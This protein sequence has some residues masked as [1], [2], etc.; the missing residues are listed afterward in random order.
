MNLV[1]SIN[2]TLYIH[3][4]EV[5]L[6][7]LLLVALLVTFVIVRMKKKNKEENPGVTKHVYDF[8]VEKLIIAEPTNPKTKARWDYTRRSLASDMEAARAFRDMLEAAERSS[9]HRRE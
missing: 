6:I 7:A 4:H 3:Q 2:E 5:R 8:G 1:N 9:Y